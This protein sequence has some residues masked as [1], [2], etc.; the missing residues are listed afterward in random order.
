MNSKQS[1]GSTELDFHEFIILCRVDLMISREGPSG[2]VSISKYIWSYWKP[3]ACLSLPLNVNWTRGGAGCGP[4]WSSNPGATGPMAGLAQCFRLLN[5]QTLFHFN[6]EATQWTQ[7]SIKWNRDKSKR[8]TQFIFF[9]CKILYHLSTFIIIN[10][11]CI[12]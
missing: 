1:S 7:S 11:E 9:Y 5:L 12:K 3:F 10:D 6:Q 8:A 4:V 2:H